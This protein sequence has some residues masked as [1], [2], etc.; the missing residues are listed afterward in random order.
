LIKQQFGNQH[1]RF[2]RTQVQAEH[3]LD[4][5][6]KRFVKSKSVQFICFRV[7]HQRGDA[8]VQGLKWNV[9]EN[10]MIRIDVSSIYCI[11]FKNE[12]RVT[13][14]SNVDMQI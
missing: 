10:K 1:L 8:F 6:E 9:S 3:V 7:D 12:W 13:S 11:R 2:Q 14:K 5:Q 4:G